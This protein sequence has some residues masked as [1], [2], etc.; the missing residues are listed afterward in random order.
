MRAP[1]KLKKLH[2]QDFSNKNSPRAHMESE[3]SVFGVAK[4]L[5][6]N[7]DHKRQKI[8]NKK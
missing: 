6:K 5:G 1:R 3:L 2:F 4:K 8:K 7:P